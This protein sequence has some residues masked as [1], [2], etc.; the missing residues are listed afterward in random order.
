MKEQKWYPKEIE[1]IESK[2]KARGE[3]LKNNLS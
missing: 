3:W 1:E 2:I